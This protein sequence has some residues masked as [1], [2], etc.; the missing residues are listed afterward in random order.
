MRHRF[1]AELIGTFGIVFAPVALSASK[2]F[3]GGDGSLASA[4][5]VSGLAV[6]AM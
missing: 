1:A 3:S 6:T 4:A 2:Q 5:W